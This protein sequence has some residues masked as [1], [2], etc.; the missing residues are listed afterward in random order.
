MSENEGPN[1]QLGELVIATDDVHFLGYVRAN[2]GGPP[3][4]AEL[5]VGNRIL[6]FDIY[7]LNAPSPF[8]RQKMPS[9]AM[10]TSGPV[11]VRGSLRTHIERL[12]ATATLQEISDGP[13]AAHEHIDLPGGGV[14][15][16]PIEYCTFC[17][18]K[19]AAQRVA[20]HQ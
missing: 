9:V 1:Y 3:E 6:K 11:R 4:A 5:H 7:F 14:Y 20:D 19:P 2:M 16:G 17:K 12:N 8:S 15:L 18:L 10:R 13:Q